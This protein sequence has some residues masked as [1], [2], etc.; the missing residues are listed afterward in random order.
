MTIAPNQKGPTEGR[1][2]YWLTPVASGK[3]LAAQEVIHT[4]VGQERIYALGERTP[5]RSQLKPGDWISFYASGKGVIGH[6]RLISAPEKKPHHRASKF[7]RYPWLV[8]LDNVQL[9]LDE[10]IAIDDALRRR[11]DAFRDR[12]PNKPWS[13]LVQTTR[14]ITEH[15][16]AILTRR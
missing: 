7:T 16:F 6:A 8:Q 10:P 5:S 2:A 13:W 14:K 1:V 15:D 4:L 12:E 11:L 3:L 9:Y